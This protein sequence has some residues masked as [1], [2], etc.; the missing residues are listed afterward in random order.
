MRRIYQMICCII[1]ISL[2]IGCKKD[3]YAELNKGNS[4]LAIVA[5]KSTIILNQREDSNDALLLSWTT[6]TNGGT[7]ASIFYQLKIDKQ[8]NN[9]SAP[10]VEDLGNSLSKK[11][12]VGSLN[13][14]LLSQW[15]FAPGVEATLEAKIIARVAND[16]A[17][18]DSSAIVTIK[19]TPYDPVTSTLYIIGDAAPNGWNAGSATALT[20][21]GAGKFSWEGNLYSGEFK[22]ITNLGQFLP[23]YN[24]GADNGKLL[25]R[26][27]DSEPDDKFNITTPGLYT[28]SINL[29]DL[30]AS[31]EAT[32]TPPYT[33]LWMLGDA[34]PTGWNIDAPTEMRVDSSNLFVFGYNG[35]LSAGE[36]KIPTTTGNFST[37]YYMPLV[38]HQDIT[39]TGVQLVPVGGPDNK[40]K[41]TTAGPYKVKLNLQTMK[42]DI[43]PFVPFT[44]IWMV[45]DAS[46]VG[47]NI[48][49][50]HPMAV[51]PVNPYVFSY[52]GPMA[53]GEFKFPVET[54]NWGG[55]FFMPVMNGSGP[56]STQMKFVPGGNP[57]NKWKIAVA[58]NYKIT[59]NQLFETISIVKM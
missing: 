18:M 21:L 45:G 59:I 7:D 48:D 54:G 3:N 24:K 55:D 11:F 9:F 1:S 25:Y 47:W 19:A 38:N 12:T 57:D 30:T 5:D 34:T 49:N 52:S 53:V 14:L 4:P 39:E 51:D 33:R 31:I 2:F 56:G 32:T 22:F 23:S 29:L 20:S 43:V 17:S 36:F 44:Q 15:S 8:G 16:A 42:M 46:P 37:D 28:I 10:V 58:G 40:W 41:I 6:G 27:A 35:L 26:S 50:P 13:S